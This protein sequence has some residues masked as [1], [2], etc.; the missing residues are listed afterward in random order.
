MAGNWMSAR[1]QGRVAGLN[2]ADTASAAI[3]A[4]QPF[5]LVSFYTS[6]GFGL[7]VSFGGDIRFLPDRTAV[8]RTSADGA[9]HTRLILRGA[10]IVG[11]TLVNRVYEMGTVVKLIQS[12][13][14]VSAKLKELAD[15]EWDLKQLVPSS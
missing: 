5:Q 11:V 12:R 10:N 9:S 3:S 4:K 15:A 7:N 8:T 13:A 1:E 6:H 14:D 2:M